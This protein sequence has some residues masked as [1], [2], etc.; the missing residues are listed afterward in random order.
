MQ[1]IHFVI[2]YAINLTKSGCSYISQ[3]FKFY[4]NLSGEAS[5][6]G[7][8]YEHSFS[9]WSVHGEFC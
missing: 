8:K 4:D 2:N 9:W 3:R 7:L 5:A 1:S 6:F